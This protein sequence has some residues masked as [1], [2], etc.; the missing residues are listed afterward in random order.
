[1]EN[2]NV[3]AYYGDYYYVSEKSRLAV[4]NNKQMINEIKLKSDCLSLTVN[5]NKK[6]IYLLFNRENYFY[7]YNS[8][9]MFKRKIELKHVNFHLEKINNISYYFDQD[10]VLI[11]T[12]KRLI[13]FSLAGEYI[14][15][16]YKIKEQIIEVGSCF[17]ELKCE[18]NSEFKLIDSLCCNDRIYIAYKR[19][20][21]Y[22]ISKL[23][24]EVLSKPVYTS[25]ENFKK[26][27]IKENYIWLIISINN[28]SK[29]IC[30]TI[31][32]ECLDD[33]KSIVSSVASIEN[34]LAKIL[35]TEATKIK[36]LIKNTSSSTDLICM[37]ESV[38][39]LIYKITILEF[40][41]TEK[42]SLIK[43]NKYD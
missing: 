16:I 43:E 15:T 9:L 28:K 37:N 12:S 19:C 21:L 22:F 31:E 32:Y 40:I 27:F 39:K 10:K 4:Y 29:V 33:N 11:T 6:E 3:I 7:V 25:K 5:E 8:D 35:C 2:L 41:L 24:G 14:K 20:N 1:M 26:L 17:R 30:T 42:L 23:D 18:Q 13:M 38:N 34:C 36:K